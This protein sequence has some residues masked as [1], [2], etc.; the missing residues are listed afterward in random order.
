MEFLKIDEKKQ[1][2]VILNSKSVKIQYLNKSDQNK[3]N[4]PEGIT[5]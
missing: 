5:G 3:K 2:N 1:R 4:S